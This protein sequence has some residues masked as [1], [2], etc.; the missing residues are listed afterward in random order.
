VHGTIL[1]DALLDMG[2]G[3]E[4]PCGGRGTC[5]RCRVA[6]EGEKD[7]VLT[8]RERVTRDMT[9]H[10]EPSRAGL[11]VPATGVDPESTFA[12]A[13]DIGTTTVRMSLVDI[14]KRSRFGIASFLNPQRRYGHDVISRIAAGPSARAAM[15]E[16]IRKAV[17]V[18]LAD[19]LRII[20]LPGDRVERI[21]FSGN[22]VMLYLLFGLDAEPLGRF[23]Y[24]AEVR[25]FTKMTSSDIGLTSLP[26]A[27]VRALPVL[28][29][30]IGAD[31]VG[32]LALSREQGIAES[33]FFIDLGTNG[34]I[35][36]TGRSGGIFSGSCAMGTALEGMNISWGMTAGTGAVTHVSE[37]AGRLHYD[38]IGQGEPSGMTGTALIDLLAILLDR[39]A[40][41]S[42]GVLARN[43]EGY[44]SQSDTSWTAEGMRLWGEVCLTQK[45]I[46]SVQLAKAASLSASRFL[47]EAAGMDLEEVEHVLI[48]GAF[49]EHLDLNS[50]ER[51]GFIPAFPNARK[52]FLGNTSLQAAERVC[53]DPDFLERAAILRDKTREVVLSALPGFQDAFIGSLDFPEAR[54]TP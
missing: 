26:S 31:L 43:D 37:H 9:V 45:D 46:R 25:D 24:H 32:G 23:P 17:D 39:G 27:E 53:F 28:S 6:V 8:C 15:T 10:A 1:A 29:A 47:L 40:V 4:T 30:F 50:F 48:A 42:R 51:L 36:V 44:P 49:G 19:T 11:E 35:F 14:R 13:V 12:L 22:T 52:E 3:L 33:A 5:R 7:P 38:M 54:R 16:L 18:R 20:G 2:I 34:E 41:S 21:V